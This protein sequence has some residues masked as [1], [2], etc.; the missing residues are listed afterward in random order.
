M[1]KPPQPTIGRTPHKPSVHNRR[2]TTLLTAPRIGEY[3]AN[4]LRV[5]KIVKNSF[6]Q[7]NTSSLYLSRICSRER[8][9]AALGVLRRVRAYSN[10]PGLG[11]GIL[12]KIPLQND[13]E[14]SREGAWTYAQTRAFHRGFRCCQH[15]CSCYGDFGRSSG[16]RRGYRGDGGGDLRS[17]GAL[18]GDPVGGWH[19]SRGVQQRSLPDERAQR[20]DSRRGEGSA[21]R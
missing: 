17:P 3:T 12:Q 15:A 13:I 8:I 20:G 7:G 14:N 6:R 18:D 10:V 5:L 19:C 9:F 11:G 4:S 21:G 2:R 1:P 16:S